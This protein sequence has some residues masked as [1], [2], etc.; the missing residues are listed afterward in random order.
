MKDRAFR[1]FPILIFALTLLALAP[2]AAV[3]CGC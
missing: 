1:Q 3:A 2:G